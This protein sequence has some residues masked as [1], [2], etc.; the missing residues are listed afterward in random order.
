M[1]GPVVGTVIKRMQKPCRAS[2]LN[3][4]IYISYSEEKLINI[5]GN[6]CKFIDLL[7]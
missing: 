3:V 5:V 1:S 4:V 2:V 7:G 6:F